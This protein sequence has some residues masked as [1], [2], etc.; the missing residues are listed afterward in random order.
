MFLNSSETTS[1]PLSNG[2][3]LYIKS[4][5]GQKG[6]SSEPPRTP[7]AYGP[8]NAWHWH[9]HILLLSIAS[10]RFII[11]HVIIMHHSRTYKIKGDVS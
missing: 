3:A 10:Y 4:F 5:G 2:K 6:G 9:T 7:R 11:P 8:V 1:G